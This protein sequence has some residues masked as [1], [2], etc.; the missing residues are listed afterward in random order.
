MVL[1][2]NHIQLQVT[3]VISKSKVLLTKLLK[4]F[5]VKVSA[6]YIFEYFPMRVKSIKILKSLSYLF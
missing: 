3:I 6:R 4:L 2:Q 1:V 5:L